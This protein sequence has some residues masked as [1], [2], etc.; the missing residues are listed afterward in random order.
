MVVYEVSCQSSASVF[1]VSARYHPLTLEEQVYTPTQNEPHNRDQI[2]GRQPWICPFHGQVGQSKH[3]STAS[4]ERAQKGENSG[5]VGHITGDVGIWWIVGMLDAIVAQ[6]I[7]HQGLKRQSHR[8]VCRNSHLVL[9]TL[10]R[11]LPNER[12]QKQETRESSPG[13]EEERAHDNPE[14]N[15]RSTRNEQTHDSNNYFEHDDDTTTRPFS[16]YNSRLTNRKSRESERPCNVPGR[17]INCLG[18]V[19]CRFI[20]IRSFAYH[21]SVS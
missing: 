14:R 10:S 1:L 17:S 6:C 5:L 19:G 4:N 9:A 18:S 15:C 16:R 12:G 3:C 7:I 21:H 8:R 20:M 13:Y 2:S 11:K